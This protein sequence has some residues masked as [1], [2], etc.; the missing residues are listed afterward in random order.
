VTKRKAIEAAWLAKHGEEVPPELAATIDRDP[1]DLAS[2]GVLAD[3]L[4]EAGEPRGA[5]IMAQLAGDDP[6]ARPSHEKRFL[7]P[8]AK[9]RSAPWR[10]ELRWRAGYIRS[11]KLGL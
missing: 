1:D 7:G 5:L 11:A 3:A 4:L 8:L 9:Y 2:Y 6:L 10:C